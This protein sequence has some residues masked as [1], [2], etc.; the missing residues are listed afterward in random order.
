MDEKKIPEFNIDERFSLLEPKSRE[1]SLRKQCELLSVAR[2]RHYYRPQESEEKS[3]GK[4]EIC[5]RMEEIYTRT[6]TYGYRRMAAQLRRENYPVGRKRIRNLMKSMCLRAIYPKKRTTVP[7]QYAAKAPYRLRDVKIERRNQVWSTDITYIKLERGFVYL[8]AVIDWYSRRVMSWELSTAAD[9]HLCVSV[10][11]KALA[12]G[13]RP[14]I[15]NTDQGSQYTSEAFNGRLS[16]IPGV[17]ISM[18]G[19]GRA[20]DN[21]FVERLWR[22]VKYEEVL[23]SDYASVADARQRLGEYIE[24][25]NSGRLH[26]SLGYRTPDE[27]YFSRV[28]SPIA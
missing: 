8:T 13:E 10:L 23:L 19:K 7:A 21:I 22:T 12:T 25:Y 14:E 27:I 26:Q 15:F 5:D 6:P 20:L 2:S 11:E 4:Q 1:L 18:D 9:T 28:G 24:W 16:A 3:K 17:Q